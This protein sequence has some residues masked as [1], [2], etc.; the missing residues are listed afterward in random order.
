MNTIKKAT[1]LAKEM[2]SG[3]Y[4]YLY[5]GKGQNYT[6]ALVE[7]LAKQYPG[8][9]TASLKKEALKD[10]NKGFK[11]I[12]CS[13]YICEVLGISDI[14]SAQL[15][16]SAIQTLKITKANA[17][18]GMVLWK[19]G[20][21]A[22]V[23]DNLKIYEAKST[24]ADLTVSSWDKRASAFT[25][26]LVVKGSALA[27]ELTKTPPKKPKIIIAAPTI[28]K[29]SRGTQVNYL[30][31]DLNYLLSVGKLKITKLEEDGS[32]GKKTEDAIKEFQKIV[33]F[34]GKDIDG[35]YGPKSYEKMKNLLG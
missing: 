2:V 30:Q 18:E 7:K 20:H 1:E 8:T 35:I 10:A 9:F 5:G 32:C 6:A 4:R 23:G 31:Q 12:D 28:R 33:G 19:S 26:L 11:A 17:R 15:K 22:Y 34:T 14:G 16:T 29:G 21:V 3:G 24:S 25:Y 13:G 27:E